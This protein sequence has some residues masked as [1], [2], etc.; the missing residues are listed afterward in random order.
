MKVHEDVFLNLVRNSLWDTKVEV[1]T[2][3]QDWNLVL[4]LA[5]SQAMSTAVSKALLHSPAILKQMSAD[6]QSR[7]R[8]MLM[9]NVLMHSMANSTLQILV[10]TL[11]NSGVECV[12]LKGQGLAANY[13][14][15]ELREC[16]DIDLYVGTENYLKTYDILKRVVDK[17]DDSSALNNGGKHFHAKLSEISIE[18]HQFSEV[19]H[20]SSFDH[21]YQRY[22]QDG[23]T[24]NLVPIEFGETEVLTPADNFNAF[25]VFNHLWNHFLSV[26]VGV[27][28]LCD[29][30]MLLHS[31]ASNM[32]KKY[33]RRILTEMKLMGSWKTFGCIVVDILGLPSEEF[34]FY[35]VKYTDKAIRVLDF[36]LKDGDLGRETEF[37]RTPN[38]GYFH[39]KFCSLK[40]YVKRFKRLVA[41][42]PDHACRQL[43]HSIIRGLKLLFEDF[44]LYL[45]AHRKH[46]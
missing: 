38:K 8:N 36:I 28:Q 22:A 33:L 43:L 3:F 34:P 2:D 26:G 25:Y 40:Y 24:Q 15:P 17:I 30:A 46:R 39:E 37:I 21:I 45:P 27:R 29:W 11:R 19:L 12:L 16:G 20:S 44:I 41:L 13:L 10:N 5:E 18:V 9:S 14:Y 23:L 35:D 4:F 1:P 6:C 42:F 31:R 7:M 32:D